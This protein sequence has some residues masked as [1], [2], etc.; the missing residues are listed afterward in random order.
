MERSTFHA[1]AR[2]ASVRA[3]TF[4]FGEL[5]ESRM[6][7][8]LDADGIVSMKYDLHVVGNSGASENMS[9]TLY[10]TVDAV[11]ALRLIGMR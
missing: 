2:R 5:R 4:E 9:L 8:P 10:F 6:A 1:D 3:E 11:G 7:R